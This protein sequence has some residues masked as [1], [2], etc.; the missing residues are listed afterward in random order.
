MG[1][2]LLRDYQRKAINECINSLRNG[3]N[4][5]LRAPTGSG[6]TVMGC[7][8][9][10]HFGESFIFAAH[11]K[12]LVD[13]I[14]ATFTLD[15][16]IVTAG[17]P[18]NSLPVVGSIQ[19]LIR[20]DLQKPRLLIIDEA[21][22]SKSSSV[23]QLIEKCG[24]PVL[25]LTAT[26]KRLDGKGLGDIYSE[27]VHCP[28]SS[29]LVER[30]HLVPLRVYAP[31]LPDLSSTNIRAGDYLPEQVHTKMVP[32]IGDIVSEWERL[33]SDRQTVVFS[34]NIEHAKQLAEAFTQAGYKAGY[35]Y[36]ADPERESKI[37]RWQAGEIQV[38]CNVQLLCEGFDYPNLGC[39]IMA[40]PTKSLTIYLQQV[41]RIM[42][43]APGK[44]DA[45]LIDHAGNTIEHG[46]PLD[47]RNWY[48]FPT[49]EKASKPLH[50]TICTSCFRTY[51]NTKKECPYCGEA[52]KRNEKIYTV[53]VEGQLTEKWESEYY[54]IV[55][56]RRE[57]L[58]E[59][60][61]AKGY[62]HNWVYYRL[63]AEFDQAFIDK[64]FPKR[65]IPIWVLKRQN[66]PIRKKSTN[67]RVRTAR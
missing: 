49:K 8:V 44:Q 60:R 14:S 2:F 55:K 24:C 45:I 62:K 50:V 19:T 7:A 34:V 37:K 11:R 29:E 22:I 40:R 65:E 51:R 27:I 46:L 63:I 17:K 42:R 56:Q 21:H 61:K 16:D 54:S 4:V 3:N 57:E 13:Q 12:E 25:G 53:E 5:I 48:L 39:C 47:K 26:P 32:L 20:R 36:G 10:Q 23:Q 59:I 15:H 31:S 64:H 28:D 52:E 66:L 9:A 6:K 67:I 1:N 58:K 41:G 38:L 35:V 33:G 18:I 30:G 43:K